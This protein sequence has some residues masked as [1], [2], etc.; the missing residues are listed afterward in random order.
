MAGG[1]YFR[2]NWRGIALRQGQLGS[3]RNRKQKSNQVG[4]WY[5]MRIIKGAMPG[6]VGP[7]RPQEVI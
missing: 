2:E 1:N 6:L 7:G 3:F 4:K 5:E